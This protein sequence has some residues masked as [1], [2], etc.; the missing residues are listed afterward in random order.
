V[1]RLFIRKLNTS[2]EGGIGALVSELT[3]QEGW[4][5]RGGRMDRGYGGGIFSYGFGGP[6]EYL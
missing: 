6:C 1:T 3:W 2:K 4:V 5:I